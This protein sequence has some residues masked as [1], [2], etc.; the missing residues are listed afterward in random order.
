MNLIEYEVYIL[1]EIAS[2]NVT[3]TQTVSAYNNVV[4]EKFYFDVN[5]DSNKSL[6]LQWT[7]FD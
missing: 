3:F 5:I 4:E 2:Q 6:C 7:H 1:V